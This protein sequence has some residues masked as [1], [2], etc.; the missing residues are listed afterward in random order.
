[1]NGTKPLVDAEFVLFILPI[2]DFATTH[3]VYFATPELAD[4]L[5]PCT[6]LRARSF[7]LRFD[8]RMEELG[9]FEGKELPA[10]VCFDV[11][12]T[13]GHDDFSEVRGAPGL[14]VSERAMEVLRRFDLGIA[15]ISE[16]PA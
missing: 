3:P 11:T 2:P 10:L 6:G 9:A 13:F 5:A 12:G 8:D 7:S 1:M 14:V 16:Y 15:K 4:A